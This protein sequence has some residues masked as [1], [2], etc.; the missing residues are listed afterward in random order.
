MVFA[1]TPTTPTI[2]RAIP[3][4]EPLFS[5]RTQPTASASSRTPGAA[6]PADSVSRTRG[7]AARAPVEPNPRARAAEAP[8]VRAGELER[9]DDWR[10]NARGAA[11]RTREAQAAQPA[12]RPREASAPAPWVSQY[13][14]TQVERAGPVA[15]Y[16]ACREMSRQAG[17][18]VSDSTT[19]RIQ[20]ATG[21]DSKG[22]V[23]TTPESVA[24]G[25]AAIDR[26][27]AAGRPVT[28]G[29]SAFDSDYNRDKV[30]DHFVLITGRGTDRRGREFYTY[31][32]PV[33][34]SADQGT[35][36]RFYVDPKSGNLHQD[37]LIGHA[38]LA[39][40]VPGTAARRRP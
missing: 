26:E 36:H 38:E 13:D 14:A 8:G 9:G 23:T 22:R 40:V 34:R 30:T 12:G 15:C 4:R 29:V 10:T 24:R 32:D 28:V 3:V 6:A 39:M 16:R 19:N 27:L 31:N 21:E 7:P 18:N 20:V 11:G 33:A 5:R 35:Q 37:G 25:R 17:V 1:S 2:R